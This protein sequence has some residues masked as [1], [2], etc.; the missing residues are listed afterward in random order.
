[1]NIN[2]VD[3][4]I[5]YPLH[6][7]RIQCITMTMLHRAYTCVVTRTHSTFGDRAFAAA[8][9]GLWNSLPSHLRDADLPYRLLQ[10]VTSLKTFLYG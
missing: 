8:G 10:S 6:G 1:M 9:P 4:E 5:Y 2:I 3:I 7:K